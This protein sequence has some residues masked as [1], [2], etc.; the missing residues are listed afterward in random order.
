MSQEYA[1]QRNISMPSIWRF[2]SN[3]AEQLKQMTVKKIPQNTQVSTKLGA[4]LLKTM[5]TGKCVNF[6]AKSSSEKKLNMLLM[7][8]Y[9]RH[10]VMFAVLLVCCQF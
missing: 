4:S 2:V 8:F 7:K 3:T 9:A 6:Q 10:A 5:C 1:E